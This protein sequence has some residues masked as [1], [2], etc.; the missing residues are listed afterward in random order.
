MVTC[1]A[2]GLLAQQHNDKAQGRMG[3]DRMSGRVG[4]RCPGK[5][6]QH[7]GSWGSTEQGYKEIRASRASWVMEMATGRMP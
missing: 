5:G 1:I 3:W 4:S 7:W 2:L 6:T